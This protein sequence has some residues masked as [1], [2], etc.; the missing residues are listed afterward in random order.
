M[1]TITAPEFKAKCLKLMAG[2][3]IMIT[4]KG[5]PVSVLKPYHSL[6]KTLF[7][8]YTGKVQSK[9]DPIAPLDIKLDAG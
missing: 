2:E 3:E 6:P 8:L 4:K 7:G 1:Q 5:K 9:N